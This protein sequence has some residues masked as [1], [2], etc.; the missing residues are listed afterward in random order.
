MREQYYRQRLKCIRLTFVLKSV[1]GKIAN[2]NQTY[3]LKIEFNRFSFPGKKMLTIVQLFV[4]IN[5]FKI[6]F[7]G[8]RTVTVC[9]RRET[10]K[11]CYFIIKLRLELSKRFDFIT[12]RRNDF[13]LL[14]PYVCASYLL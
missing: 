4:S 6:V 2:R 9:H 5:V 1:H 13:V 3:R 11:T 14:V 12:Y 8:A 10:S 7:D